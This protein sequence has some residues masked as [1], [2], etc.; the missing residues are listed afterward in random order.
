MMFE[1]YQYSRNHD[2]NLM[3]S[4]VYFISDIDLFVFA[5][6]TRIQAEDASPPYCPIRNMSLN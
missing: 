4:H 6:Y 5:L 1:L 3:F 2:N